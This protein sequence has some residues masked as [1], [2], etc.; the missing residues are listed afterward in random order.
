[1]LWILDPAKFFPSST[2]MQES[3]KF[4]ISCWKSLKSSNYDL[5]NPTSMSNFR[6]NVYSDAQCDLVPFLQFKNT[7]TSSKVA[8]YFTF[9]K[10]YQRYQ[11]AQNVTSMKQCLAIKI[12]LC[13]DL[14]LFF[15]CFLL[16]SLK[17]SENLWF[18]DVFM[19]IKREQLGRNRFSKEYS[20]MSKF[21]KSIATL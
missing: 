9:F 13:F 15:Q 1:M 11:I 2:H 18:S 16:I 6:Y 8:G 12:T 20:L 14:T 21:A 19:G 17:T 4:A 3:S 7:N 5:L 10:L